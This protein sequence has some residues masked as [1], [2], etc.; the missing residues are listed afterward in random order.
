LPTEH[1]SVADALSKQWGDELKDSPTEL[2]GK[3]KLEVPGLSTI[4]AA[5]ADP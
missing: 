2:A 3:P 1:N 5:D 4:W